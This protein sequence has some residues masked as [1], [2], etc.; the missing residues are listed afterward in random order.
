[1]VAGANLANPELFTKV[2]PNQIYITKLQVDYDYQTVSKYL[3]SYLRI[4]SVNHNINVPMNY[5]LLHFY[6]D[7]N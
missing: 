5:S 6:Y 7:F 4:Y 2:L 3:T 1:M